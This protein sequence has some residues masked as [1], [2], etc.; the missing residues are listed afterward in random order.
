MPKT[1][2]PDPKTA[3]LRRHSSLNPNPEKVCDPLFAGV[4]FFDARDLLQ[5]KY[6]MVRRVRVDGQPVSHSAAAFGFSRPSFYQALA[7]LERGGLAALVPRKPGPRRSHKLDTEVM[8]FLQQLRAEDPSL[9]PADLADSQR[10]CRQ[11]RWRWVGGRLRA[12][13][14]PGARGR[15]DPGRPPRTAPAR[16]RRDGRLDGSVYDVRGR[17]RSRG[18]PQAV[19]GAAASRRLPRQPGS[20][21]GK[22]DDVRHRGDGSMSSEASR[23]VTASHLARSAY[24][25]VRQSTMRQ[26]F[27]NTESTERQYALRQHAVALGWPSESV[28]VID[29]DLGQSGASAVDRAGFQRLV[30][31]VGTG[32]AGIVLGLEVSRLARNCADWHRLLEI[33]ALT[34]TL[35]LDEDGVYDPAHFNDRLLLGLKGTMSEAELHVL[36]AR[37]R[38]GI[39]NKARRGELRC[40]LPVGLVYD[41]T[42]QVV[43]DPDTQVQESV[44]LLFETFARTGTLYATV[45]YFRQQGL[46]FP[47]RVAAGA[48]KGD[49]AWTPLSFGRASSALH[50]PWYAGAYVYGR[51]RWRKQPDGR[52]RYQRLPQEQW[53]VLIQDAH[54][55]YISWPEYERIAQQLRAS[56]KALGFE[57]D[58]GPPREGPALLQ[59]RVLCGL[60]G[61]RMHVHY[62]HRRG[63]ELVTN[64]MCVGRGKL[65]GDPLCQSIQGTAID[66][67]IGTL[68]VEA[69]TPMALDLV[70]GIQHEIATR[71][72][73]ADRLRHRQVERAQYEVDRARHRYMQV[74]P[75]NRLVASSLEADW[76]VK[77]RA[78][79]EA[80]EDYQRQR[81]T[82]RLVVDEQERQRILNLATDFPAVWRDPNTAQRERKRMLALLI[83]DVTLIKQRQI[84]AAVRFR[85]GATTTLT[86]PRPL[87]AQQLRTTHPEVRQQIDALLDEYTDAQVAHRL[88]ERGLR[89]GAGDVFDSTSVKWVRFSAKLKSLKERLLEAGML[90]RR[91]TCATLAVSRTKLGRW[92]Q[93]GRV[94]ARICNDL[95]EWLY[96]L[97]EQNPP[98]ANRSPEKMGTF[99]AGGA[100]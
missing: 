69:V 13:A 75:A 57:R 1:K 11:R 84:T 36:R 73:Q 67:A 49:L 90:T 81:A 97:P 53:Q 22:H 78:L 20:R 24:L 60:C 92:R 51:S 28:I 58:S 54:P 41:A 40:R 39:L 44:R 29:S 94:K 8:E 21:A 4:D 91:Q 89:T 18:C 12:A 99:T 56:A 55:A 31:E 83:E 64:Y 50:N 87:T 37:L 65:F 32:R 46:L 63:G 62:N 10:G 9:R 80:E 77:L 93:E 85:G 66:A 47:T 70:L 7:A 43:F 79:G 26:V 6:E 86:L 95:G 30:A 33:C 68:L 98:S 42:G 2:P 82:D 52:V 16:A 23:K 14:P 74:D 25:Y 72:D 19:C 35:I 48:R 17:R 96:W 27:E 38:G 61:S 15:N 45:K 76:N 34:D 5:V 3:A 88:N 100:V 71:L 59:G